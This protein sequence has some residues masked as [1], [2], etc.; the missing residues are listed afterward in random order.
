MHEDKRVKV[1]ESE[2]KM[3]RLQSVAYE[4][5]GDV[6]KFHDEALIGDD[7]RTLARKYCNVDAP[8]KKVTRG[9]LTPALE[10]AASAMEDNTVGVVTELDGKY[11]VFKC[12][13]SH[14]TETTAERRKSPQD[15]RL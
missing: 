4:K 3:I 13:V 6:E 14:D 12:P 10:R 7:F 1:N 11:C 5:R 8:V 9:G 15:E 2:A